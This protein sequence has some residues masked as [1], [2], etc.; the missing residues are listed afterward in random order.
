MASL[1]NTNDMTNKSTNQTN[2][3]RKQH[4]AGQN[5][6]ANSNI[7]HAK[8]AAAN[9]QLIKMSG[10]NSSNVENLSLVASVNFIESRTRGSNKTTSASLSSTGPGVKH[11]VSNFNHQ[12]ENDSMTNF[13]VENNNQLT[14]RSNQSVVDSS[15]NLNLI[16]Q[17][18]NE[19]AN[20]LLDGN[21]KSMN[22]NVAGPNHN[23]N[24]HQLWHDESNSGWTGT[25][26]MSDRSSV[27][28]IDDG[29]NTFYI[30]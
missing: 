11:R 27:Y 23:S 1:N 13:A 17:S 14:S 22:N 10:A 16:S 28:S 2:Q 26:V 29:V 4:Q 19:I 3:G 7:N 5:H 24:S 30:L 25:G 12:L 8:P 9:I 21:L 20:L 18:N 6:A 15:N